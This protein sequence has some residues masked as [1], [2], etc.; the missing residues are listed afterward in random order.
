[1][2]D[3]S[4]DMYRHFGQYERKFGENSQEMLIC[5]TAELEVNCGMI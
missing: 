2:G 5:V 3:L 4:K 1:M